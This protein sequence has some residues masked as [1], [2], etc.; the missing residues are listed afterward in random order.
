MLTMTQTNT[1]RNAFFYEGDTISQVARDFKVDRKTVRK[2]ISQDD[3]NEVPPVAAAKPLHPKLDPYKSQIDEWLMADKQAKKKQRHT[4]K[5]VY[6]R[7]CEVHGDNFEC[8]YRTVASYVSLRKKE[9]YK[10]NSCH[11]PLVH[12][13]GEAQVDFGEVEFYENGI[14]HEGAA[15]NVSFPQSNAGYVQLFKG[16][17]QECLLTG[18]RAIFEHIGGVPNRIW[19]DNPS[20]LVSEIR[21]DG[22]R[23]LTDGFLRFKQHYGFEATFCNPASGHE[24]GSVEGKVGYQ[25]RNFLVPVPE[26]RC[27]QE[28][29]LAL[30]KRCDDDMNRGHYRKEATIRELFEDDRRALPSLPSV[31]YEVCKYVTMKPNAYAKFCLDGKYTYSTAPKFANAPVL[32][33]ITA[34]EVIPLDENH[35]EIVRHKRLYGSKQESMQWL[36]YLVQLSRSPGALKYSGIYEMLPDPLK[37]YLDKRSKSERG[38]VLR[39]IASLCE[40]NSF[41]QAVNAVSQA[42]KHGVLDTDSLRALHNR[43]Y[44]IVPS[45]EPC[46]LPPGVADVNSFSFDATE[47]DKAFLKGRSRVC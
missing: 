44:G 27:L 14:R 5:R 46:T 4:A 35:R 7:L 43:L 10:S 23:K 26:L 2:Y 20:T 3:W 9:V 13:V 25:R 45:L 42:M 40:S 37:E 21:K 16:E 8:S 47:Y 15:L 33:K 19:F 29:N 22:E 18:L 6:D 41:E 1:I 39:G 36:P 30:L 38:V 28:F 31:P 32:V 11:L 24:K 34:M 17:N 12:K